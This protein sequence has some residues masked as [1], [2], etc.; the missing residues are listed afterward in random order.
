M[1]LFEIV[2]E[3][4][5]HFY[6]P[7]ESC[8]E[9]DQLIAKATASKVVVQF[10][11]DCAR[12]M[13]AILFFWLVCATLFCLLGFDLLTRPLASPLCRVLPVPLG[14]GTPAVKIS[15]APVDSCVDFLFTLWP[16][17]TPGQDGCVSS[18]CTPGTDVFFLTCLASNGCSDG[19]KLVSWGSLI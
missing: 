6:S 8:D 11:L 15:G 18:D 2:I 14:A 1:P 13:T 12:V 7:G 9:L 19:G 5:A 3:R 4:G 16:G 17:C 10:I